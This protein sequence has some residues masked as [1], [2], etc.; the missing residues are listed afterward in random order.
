M[1]PTC[2]ILAERYSE[3]ESQSL[4]LVDLG[5]GDG[6]EWYSRAVLETAGIDVADYLAP[7]QKKPNRKLRVIAPALPSEL[8]PDASSSFMRAWD[9]LVG[10][11]AVDVY[12]DSMKKRPGDRA[13][14]VVG[15]E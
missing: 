12:L 6:P 14:Q 15:A 5:T 13:K 8:T 4:Y 3:S 1:Y 11:S 2:K 9:A 7:S 10:G